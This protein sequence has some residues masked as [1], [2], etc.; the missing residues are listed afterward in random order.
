MNGMKIFE[1]FSWFLKRH[2][3][4]A[5]TRGGMNGRLRAKALAS[6]ADTGAADAFGDGEGREYIEP[7][8][9][10]AWVNIAVALLRS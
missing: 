5:R 10:H 7:F 1:N 3:G 6:F 9:L 2:A 8:R 4:R